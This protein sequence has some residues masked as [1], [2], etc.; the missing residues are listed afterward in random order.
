[1]RPCG[2]LALAGGTAVKVAE[3]EK[4][5]RA[6]LPSLHDSLGSVKL[7]EPGQAARS[8]RSLPGAS[9]HCPAMP[10]QAE[11]QEGQLENPLE[12]PWV[13]GLL[14]SFSRSCPWGTLLGG[15]ELALAGVSVQLSYQ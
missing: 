15:W 11:T 2:R 4:L 1:M 9:G 7:C 12:G 14:P 10:P 5:P 8:I 6:V 3:N 13:S